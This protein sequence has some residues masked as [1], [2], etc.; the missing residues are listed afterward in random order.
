[1][2][3]TFAGIQPLS[4]SHPGDAVI[5]GLA[6]V[7]AMVLYYGWF[8][9]SVGATPGKALFGRRVVDP[10]NEPPGISTAMLRALAFGV[11][12]QAITRV[13]TILVVRSVPLASV[14]LVGMI[15]SLVSLVFKGGWAVANPDPRALILPSLGM[16]LLVAGAVWTA[17]HPSRSIQDR[18]A[19]TWIVPR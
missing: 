18:L 3:K 11:P 14:P 15:L 10:A 4:P 2:N 13:A 1:L 8:E 16:A 9:G 6:A 7:A 19:G 5:V 12:L 17:L